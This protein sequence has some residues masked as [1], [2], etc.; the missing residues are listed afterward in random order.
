MTH[1]KFCQFEPIVNLRKINEIALE[2]PVENPS[3]VLEIIGKTAIEKPIEQVFA[4][5]LDSACRPIAYICCGT[6]SQTKAIIDIHGLLA[7]ALLLHSSQVILCHTH[8]SYSSPAPPSK[9]DIQTTKTLSE[10]LGW[11]G[12]RLLD[13]IVIEFCPSKNADLIKIKMTSVCKYES[14]KGT[15]LLQMPKSALQEKISVGVKEL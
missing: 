12:I 10:K 7:S 14:N 2:S 11:F 5:Y 3:D 9:T 8:P 13:S 15:R 6:G 4:I 1:N